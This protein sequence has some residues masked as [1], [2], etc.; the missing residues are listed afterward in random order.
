MP[1]TIQTSGIK[2]IGSKNTIVPTIVSTIQAHCLTG[3]SPRII[4]VFTGT[5]RVAQAF[6][7]QGWNVQT[8]D[9]SWASE[10]YA[11]AFMIR[12][13]ASGSRIGDLLKG[14]NAVEPQED[15]ITRNYCDVSGVT[16]GIV[17]MWKPENGRKADAIRNKI[18]EL[19]DTGA[20][21]HHEMMILIACLIFAL[22]KVDNSVGI[23][24]AYLKTWCKRS[25]NPLI[26]EDL[27]F[28]DGPPGTHVIGNCLSVPYT[29]ADIAYLD[30]PYSEH[31]YSTYYH[32]WDS[33]TKWD[34]PDVNLTTNRRSDRVS[35]SNDFDSSMV[36]EWNKKST[37]LGAFLDICRKLPVKWI[38]ISYNDESLVPIDTLVEALRSEFT[39]LQKITIPYKRNI[40]SQIGN[41]TLHNDEY[42]TD[43]NEI[44]ILIEKN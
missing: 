30:P 43:N 18:G 28:Y 2:Y 39:T 19:Y 14:L 37:A 34:K 15:W 35:K 24:Q 12:T 25:H 36:S 13:Q 11:H 6:R 32:I 17:R 20:I 40:M 27:P 44:L 31:S 7:S 21:T 4:D 29:A 42:K 1:S 10:P 22:D 26:L 16:G 33:I 3:S 8:S 9:I 38:I 23:Q 41:A 5:T